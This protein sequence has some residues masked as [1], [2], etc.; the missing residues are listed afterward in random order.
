MCDIRAQQ[1]TARRHQLVNVVESRNIYDNNSLGKKI[2]SEPLL[3]KKVTQ[4]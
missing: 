4:L 2:L 1:E 3:E